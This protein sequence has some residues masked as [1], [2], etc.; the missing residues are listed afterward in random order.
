MDIL[1]LINILI[2][3]PTLFEVRN[4]S[5]IFEVI[6]KAEDKRDKK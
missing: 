5:E 1:C 4:I 6:I 3:T 2:H